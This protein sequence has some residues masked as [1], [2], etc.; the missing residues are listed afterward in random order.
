MRNGGADIRIHAHGCARVKIA[1]GLIPLTRG[2]VKIQD[3][4]V[5]APRRDVGIVFQSP[6]LLPWK[7]VLQ[8]V[9]VGLHHTFESPLWNVA[10][11]LP[12]YLKE[13]LHAHE[14]AHAL[15]KFVG[16]DALSDEL[17][18]NLPYGKQRLLEIARAL[19]TQPRYI[20][21]DEPFAGID[22]IA[23]LEIQRIIGFLKSKGIGVL[24]TDHNVRETLGICDHAAII[25]EGRVLAE[26]KPQDIVQNPEVRR[27]Y[28]GENFRM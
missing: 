17:A 25:S 26:G 21:L 12:S 27:V 18:H 11:H 28:L 3:E 2:T 19:A 13:E 9:L 7:T 1:A 22:P 5:T 24:I 15:L 16:L 20:L 23:V 6:V 10:L 4:H 8:N 14:R